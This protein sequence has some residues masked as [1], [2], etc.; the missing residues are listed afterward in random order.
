MLSFS[1]SMTM[2]LAIALVI[3][4]EKD[5][6]VEERECRKITHNRLINASDLVTAHV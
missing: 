4:F 2:L 3:G 5:Y 1:T 6:L